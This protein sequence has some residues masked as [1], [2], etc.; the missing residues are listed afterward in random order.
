MTTYKLQL[1][2]CLKEG[3]AY[4]TPIKVGKFWI[5]AQVWCKE[6]KDTCTSFN[7]KKYEVKK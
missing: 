4:I 1:K 7:C 2:K 5:C 6:Y 3:N